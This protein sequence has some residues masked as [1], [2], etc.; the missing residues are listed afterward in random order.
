PLRH[1]GLAME[2]IASGE[3]DLTKRITVSSEDEIGKLGKNFNDFVESIHNLVVRVIGS[4]NEMQS[5]SQNTRETATANNESVHQ[6]QS[7]ISQVAAAIH[8]MSSTSAAVAQNAEQT[9]DSA[10]LATNETLRSE[11]AANDNATQMGNLTTEIDKST[12]VINDLNEHAKNIA[13]ILATIQGIAEQT[14]L[15]ALNAAIEAARAGEQGRGFAVVADEVRALSMRTHEAT[16]EIQ[17]MIGSL[18]TQTESAVMQMDKSKQIVEQ[19]M[20]TAN[21]VS[22]SQ[23]SIK[24]AINEINT[25]AITI[26]E[27]SKEQ[28][29]A[30]EEINRIT[31]AIQYASQ[32]LAE[33]VDTAYQQAEELNK[34]GESVRSHLGRFKT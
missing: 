20:T 12:L 6:Q 19:T 30:T 15:L 18:R 10:L 25:Q 8:E 27:S 26:A 14:N 33:N 4:A 5:L 23:A 21:S 7:E 2:D 31:Q 3:A 17:T 16:G 32:Q 24:A 13:T 22:E 29:I 28:N 9:A 11:T 34:I 1:L